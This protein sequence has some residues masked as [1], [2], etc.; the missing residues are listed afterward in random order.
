[1]GNLNDGYK[2]ACKVAL[3]SSNDLAGESESTLYDVV[4]LICIDTNRY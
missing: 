1:M 2:Y 3:Q 4:Y